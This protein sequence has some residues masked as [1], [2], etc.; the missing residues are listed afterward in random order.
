MLVSNNK[1]NF[2]GILYEYGIVNGTDILN[3]E[4]S[5][6]SLKDIKQKPELLKKIFKEQRGLEILEIINNIPDVTRT[7]IFDLCQSGLFIKIAKKLFKYNITIQMLENMTP[8]QLHENYKIPKSSCERIFQSL[9]WYKIDIEK[10]NET[11]AYARLYEDGTFI[12]SSYDYTDKEKQLIREYKCGDISANDKKRI[13]NVIILD[14]IVVSKDDYFMKHCFRDLKVKK[15]DLSNLDYSNVT[16]MSNMFEWCERLEELNL[17]NFNT[18][19]VTN[20][21]AMFYHCRN[22]KTLDLSSF[23][24]SNV[25]NMSSMFAGCEK[26]EKLIL[27]NFNTSNVKSMFSMFRNCKNLKILDLSGLNL[28]NVT[29]KVNMFS[30]CESL[31]DENIWQ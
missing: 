13:K 3:I 31:K 30:G 1:K 7:S 17:S 9:E 12:L 26:L 20:M 10:N 4:H 15:L 11:T 5:K 25:T 8:D 14:K 16:D 19:N 23:D 22:L 18:S 2:C 28:S 6:Y 21:V 24:T 27:S 29:N